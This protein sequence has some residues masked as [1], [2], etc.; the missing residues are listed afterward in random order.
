MI[1]SMM[2]ASATE[3]AKPDC[4]WVALTI[5]PKT[6]RPTMIEGKAVHHVEGELDPAC[7]AAFAELGQV[8]G[9]E[10]PI[11]A[12]ISVAIATISAVPTS[13]GADPVR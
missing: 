1:G 3:P 11:G 9:D 12:A 13:A 7:Q 4:V 2:I 10:I 8:E 5:R 6:K